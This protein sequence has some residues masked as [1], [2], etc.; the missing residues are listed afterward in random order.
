MLSPPGTI[1]CAAGARSSPFAAGKRSSSRPRHSH[2]SSR[3][4]SDR[5]TARWT[6]R[7]WPESSRF[8]APESGCRPP[9]PS[10][11]CSSAPPSSRRGPTKPT[12]QIPSP[13]RANSYSADARAARVRFPPILESRCE[14]PSSSPRNRSSQKYKRCNH[15]RG[16]HRTLRTRRLRPSL[17]PPRGS[18]TC[19]WARPALSRLRSSTS[20]PHPVSPA[21]FRHLCPPTAHS[22]SA[23]TRSMS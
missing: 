12:I 19:P 11:N 9:A 10:E 2:P 4:A 6:A 3:S 23:A 7:A 1:A 22:P 5:R 13:Q 17:T 18:H 14:L 20:F 8:P 21:R 15:P 16:V